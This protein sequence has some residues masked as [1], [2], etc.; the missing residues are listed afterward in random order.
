MSISSVSSFKSSFPGLPSA[1]SA[2][3]NS[4]TPSGTR[5]EL[6]D[7]RE[8]G[9]RAWAQE[10]KMETLR[11]KVRAQIMS[12]RKLTESGLA[13]MSKEA[14]TSIENEIA[15]LIEVKMQE[16]IAQMV[17][18]GVGTGKPQGVVMDIMV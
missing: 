11:A 17:E 13:A 1:D 4:P 8:K 10:Q 14:R 18:E 3:Q 15:K 6:D 16:A 5:T 7:I 2:R 9:L 12:D